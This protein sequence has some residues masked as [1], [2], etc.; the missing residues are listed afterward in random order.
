DKSG[1]FILYV[2]AGQSSGQDWA[3]WVKAQIVTAPPELPDLV[4][5]EV[6][7]EDGEIQYRIENQGEGSVVNPLGPTT[8]FCNALFIDGELVAR[9]Y[10]NIHEM[11]PGQWIDNPFDYEWQATQPEHKIEVCADWEGDVTESNEQNNCLEETFEIGDTVPPIVTITYSP[12]DVT[13][14]SEVTFTAR[15][16]DDSE[17]TKLEIYIDEEMV[18]ECLEPS[19]GVD[20]KG[21]TYWECIYIGGPYEEGEL[22]YHAEALDE[23]DNR[24]ST[25]EMTLEVAP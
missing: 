24:G 15:A 1:H 2:D 11:L 13:T 5:T 7:E 10:V 19:Q 6:R 25:S 23:Y 14:L 16:R 17:V 3:A 8:R 20:E 4:T 18:E 9:D 12:L 21:R 22:A